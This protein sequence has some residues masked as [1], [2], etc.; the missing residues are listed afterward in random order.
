MVKISG[1]YLDTED[2]EEDD[3]IAV[4]YPCPFCSDDYDLV[5]LCHHIDEEHQLEANHGVCEIHV[6][7][8]YRL[9]L[10]P[11]VIEASHEVV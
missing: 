6:V 3:D 7:F 1:S 4:E 9:L 10:L 2:F 11:F 5:E 8:Q